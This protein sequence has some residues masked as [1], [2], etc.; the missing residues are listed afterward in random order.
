MCS[1][2][3]SIFF[4]LFPSS[5]LGAMP[6]PRSI[7]QV[8]T[9][10]VNAKA[11]TGIKPSVLRVRRNFYALYLVR[12]ALPVRNG[13]KRKGKRDGYTSKGLI[14]A[15]RRIKI[16]YLDEGSMSV[17]EAPLNFLSQLKH[18]EMANPIEFGSNLGEAAGWRITKELGNVIRNGHQMKKG[19]GIAGIVAA[20]Y[21]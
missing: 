19:T 16:E 8:R 17:S 9:A 6:P 1:K 14:E 10:T 5:R 3:C 11:D 7:M 13:Q 4:S 12:Y 2:P 15:C 20:V 18:V 21:A